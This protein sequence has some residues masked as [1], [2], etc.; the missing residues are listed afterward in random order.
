VSSNFII[1]LGPSGVGKGTCVSLLKEKEPNFCYPLSVTTRPKRHYEQNNVH[2]VFISE[3]EFLEKKERGEFLEYAKVHNRFWYGTEKCQ[4]ETALKNNITVIKEVDYQGAL[5]IQTQLP[6]ER[7][8][9]LFILPPDNTILIQR[10]Q[11]RSH[12]SSKEVAERMKSLE[13]ELEFSKFC[14]ITV[15]SYENESLQ[16]FQEFYSALKTLQQ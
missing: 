10:I 14:D 16:T 5:Q 11:R 2:Y 4:I 1:I 12:L 15:Q 8:K 9:T 7:V 3:E 6:K 13:K